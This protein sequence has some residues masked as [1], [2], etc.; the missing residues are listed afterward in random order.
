M[1]RRRRAPTLPLGWSIAALIAAI[2]MIVTG[3]MVR[4]E[5]FFNVGFVGLI[6]G[7]VLVV[8]HVLA[9]RH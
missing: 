6:A 3:L 4:S 8:E 5:W 7:G 1:S 2:G 9:R